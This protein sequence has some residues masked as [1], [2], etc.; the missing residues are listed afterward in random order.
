MQYILTEHE[1]N[2]GCELIEVY[3]TEEMALD[4]VYIEQSNLNKQGYF[5]V[6]RCTDAEKDLYKI[7]VFQKN[8]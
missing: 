7:T 1:M 6:I 4:C 3:E 2:Q 5:T 8:E